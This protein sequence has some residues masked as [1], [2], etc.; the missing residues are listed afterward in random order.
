MSASCVDA[1]TGG[2]TTAAEFQRIGEPVVHEKVR[3]GLAAKLALAGG[4]CLLRLED[5]S[6]LISRWNLTKH[7]PDLQAVATFARQVGCEL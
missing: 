2:A 3:A 4:Y 6:F 5:G 1:G 7:C